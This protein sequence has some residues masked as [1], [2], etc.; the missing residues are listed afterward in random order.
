MIGGWEIKGKDMCLLNVEGKFVFDE[1][2]KGIRL[3]EVGIVCGFFLVLKSLLFNM[4]W[5]GVGD[6]LR[7]DLKVNCWVDLGVFS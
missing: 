7:W 3:F 5:L 6:V 2:L 1:E 4:F